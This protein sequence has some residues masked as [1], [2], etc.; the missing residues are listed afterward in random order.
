R[1]YM[2]MEYLSGQPLAASAVPLPVNQ[3]VEVLEELCDGLAAAHRAG[4]VHRDLKPENI[5]L[6]RDG[7]GQLRV[8]VLDFGIA[9]L[10]GQDRI[11]GET[12]A[13]VILGTPEFMAPEQCSSDDVDGRTDVYAVGIIAYWLLVGRVP[14]YGGWAK[15]LLAH[16]TQRPEPLD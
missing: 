5:F 1:Y 8:K 11:V 3:A 13:D 7:R 15:V 4:V 12:S 16:Q 6:L 2:V 14:F 10:F 9:K